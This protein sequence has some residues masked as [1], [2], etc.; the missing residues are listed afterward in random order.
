MIE[1]VCRAQALLAVMKD[2]E[3]AGWF[4]NGKA[5]ALWYRERIETAAGY[6]FDRI[7]DA[8]TLPGEILEQFSTC[9]G[10][11]QV[12]GCSKSAA[13]EIMQRFKK[14]EAFSH[15]AILRRWQTNKKSPTQDSNPYWWMPTVWRIG[16]RYV[17]FF[18]TS[19]QNGTN[20]ANTPPGSQYRTRVSSKTSGFGTEAAFQE[21]QV[22]Q[23]FQDSAAS[24]PVSIKPNEIEWSIAAVDRLSSKLTIEGHRAPTMDEAQE[25]VRSVETAIET[26]ERLDH[27][28]R[29]ERLE[30][31]RKA[32]SQALGM[33]ELAELGELM[34][35]KRLPEITPK[36]P[37]HR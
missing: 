15:K 24:C 17:K 4:A 10:L 32:L 7:R 13:W 31:A 9:R 22:S 29:F 14:L 33:V 27:V 6:M 28:D 19:N 11:A 37:G 21:S 3:D 20:L 23:R 18:A 5:R 30:E 35:P 2:Y 25:A 8:L 26:I 1:S 36:G 12:L 34:R 16:E